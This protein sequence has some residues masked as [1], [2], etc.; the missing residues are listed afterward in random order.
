MLDLWAYLYRYFALE[1]CEA[2]LDQ[3]FL[4]P[5]HP[6][7]Y[8]GPMLPGHLKVL[9]QLASGLEY[10]HSKKLIHR[11]IKPGN[12]LIS[13]D[14][15]GT[16]GVTMKWADFGLSKFV[17]ERGT[18]TMSGVKGSDTWMAPE[19]LKLLYDE[20]EIQQQRGTV[21]S[22]IFSEGLVF[23]YLLSAGKH[24]FGVDPEI[25]SNI[26]KNE[27]INVTTGPL[28]IFFSLTNF[29]KTIYVELLWKIYRYS[30]GIYPEFD[31]QNA[32]K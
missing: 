5:E 30:V 1:L 13:V 2:S 9:L 18:F 32:R 11:D 4:K 22:D 19:L 7:K 14:S 20:G 23:G 28:Y 3:L 24:L 29:G 15:S 27:P 25:Q 12:V 10:I 17:N 8:K 16:K 21:R 31:P 26:L 6:R